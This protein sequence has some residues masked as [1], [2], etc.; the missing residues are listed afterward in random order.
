MFRCEKHHPQGAH[1]LSLVEAVIFKILTIVAE[2]MEI[3]PKIASV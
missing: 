2:K 1:Y 3:Q